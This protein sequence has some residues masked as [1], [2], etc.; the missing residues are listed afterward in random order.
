MIPNFRGFNKKTKKMYSVEGFKAIE[1]KIY[2]CS[3]AD[4]EFRQG[5]METIHF[6]EDNL[7]D[8]ILIQS[9]GLKDKNGVEI[10]DGDIVKLQYTIASD[11]EFFR[12]TRFRGGAWRIDNR[13]RGSELWLRNE[14][15]EVIG[16]VWENPELLERG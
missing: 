7:D 6:V 8:Y 10:F 11:F 12:V 16:N 1:R 4:D 9:T 15:C 5:H 13:R 14:D 3:L 2:R